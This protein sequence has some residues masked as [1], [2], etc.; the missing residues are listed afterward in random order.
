VRTFGSGGDE[1][2]LI[3]FKLKKN[4]MQLKQQQSQNVEKLQQIQRVQTEA[5]EM[6]KLMRALH[7]SVD[8]LSKR[9]LELTSR[10]RVFDDEMAIYKLQ[11]SPGFGLTR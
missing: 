10:Q 4:H 8:S 11:A 1:I 6:R 5:D 3:C 2:L 7:E 9:N